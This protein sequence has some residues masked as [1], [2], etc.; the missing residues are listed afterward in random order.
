MLVLAGV[1]L[2]AVV[3]FGGLMMRRTQ[4]EVNAL[5]AAYPAA[6]VEEPPLRPMDAPPCGADSL[7]E[8]RPYDWALPTDVGPLKDLTL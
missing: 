4:V 1:V 7:F 2:V 8:V 6:T 3:L 5:A